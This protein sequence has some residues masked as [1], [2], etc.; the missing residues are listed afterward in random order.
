MQMYYLSAAGTSLSTQP[1]M[2][3]EVGPLINYCTLVTPHM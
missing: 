3:N 1:I 2:N